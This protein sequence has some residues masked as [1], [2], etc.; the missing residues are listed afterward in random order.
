MDIRSIK[1]TDDLKRASEMSHAALTTVTQ[2]C[3]SIVTETITMQELGKYYQ[4]KERHK[5][6][7]LCISVNSGKNK[8]CPEIS[9]INNSLSLSFKKYNIVKQYFRKI[10]VVVKYCS[11]IFKGTYIIIIIY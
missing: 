10:E 11:P 5:L 1:C 9:R 4:E 2:L 7:L 6:E 3:L 8:F